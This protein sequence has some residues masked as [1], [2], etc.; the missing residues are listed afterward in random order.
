MGPLGSE[1]WRDHFR[2]NRS[3]GL[4]LPW[5]D[6]SPLS[7]SE[8]EAVQGSIQQFQLGERANGARLVERGE[9]YATKTGD[10]AFIQ[11]LRLFVEEERRHSSYLL[12]FMRR[13]QIPPVERHWVDTAFR[14]L[15][16]LA[17]LEL[18]LRVLVTAEMIAV[19]YYRSLRD[20]TKSPLLRAISSQIL[21]D[22]AAHL[23]FQA[24]ML[25]RLGARRP[26]LLNR[27]I[28][29]VHRLLLN[30]T[31]ALVWLGHQRV[32]GAA[33]QAY[34]EFRGQA[35][36]EFDRTKR[37]ARDFARRSSVEHI[38]TAIGRV[39]SVGRDAG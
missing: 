24:S 15:R 23:S 2:R 14:R 25:G 38:G 30:L 4:G 29:G 26:D 10:P 35:L 19:P 12:R 6:R 9:K 32:F 36:R 27:G 28:W 18:S 17:G 5:S 1:F 34:A 7:A 11:A 8:R 37:L 31:A 16:G 20:A 33:G 3:S 39:D 21:K 13:E 22:E